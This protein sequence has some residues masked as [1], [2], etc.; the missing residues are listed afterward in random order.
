MTRRAFSLRLLPQLRVRAA[1]IGR[2]GILA[3]FDDAAADRAGTGEVL[4]QRL[5]VAAPDRARQL[6]QILVEGAEHFKHRIL[7]GQEYVAPHDR[8]GA[9]DAG[10]VAK[11]AR[12]EFY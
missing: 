6:G 2:R 1:E 5:A 3:D 4:E 7:V 9:R 11:T 12:R 10:E 8:I